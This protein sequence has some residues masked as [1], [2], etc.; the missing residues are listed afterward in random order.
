LKNNEISKFIMED[1]D[2]GCTILEGK[3][4]FSGNSTHILYVVLSRKEFIKLKGFIKEVDEN[5]FITVSEAHQVLGNGFK[6]MFG[7]N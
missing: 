5:A 1:L 3:G 4:A 6:D 2:R 7:E